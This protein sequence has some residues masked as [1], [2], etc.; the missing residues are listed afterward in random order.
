MNSQKLSRII[1][2]IVLIIVVIAIILL[3]RGNGDTAKLELIGNDEMIIYQYDQFID[4]GYKIVDSSSKNGFY[5]NVDGIVNSNTIGIYFLKYLLYNKNGSLV[6]Y[7]ER[8][9]IVL[10]D[11]LN[12]ISMSLNG[13][14]EE[15]YFV[16]DYVELGATAYQNNNDISHLINI[17][18]N[19]KEDE[20][21]KYEIKYQIV[22]NNKIKEII[23]YVNIID[24]DINENV[25]LANLKINLL[26]NCNNYYYTLQPDGTKEYSK[27]VS[28]SFNDVGIYNFD[29][30]L[31]NGSHKKYSIDISTIDND[32][33]V[34][35]CSLSYENNKTS[36]LMNV[37]DKSGI[38][39]YSYNGMDFYDNKTILNTIASNV[40]VRA[41]DKRNNYTDI[42][43]KAEYGTAFRNIEL[44]SN[45]NIKN[46]TGFIVYPTNFSKENQELEELMQ[47]YGYKTRGA[48]AAAGLYLAESK[49]DVPYFW[50]GKYI[51]K[52][53]NP[54]WGMRHS[55]TVGKPCS[56]PLA[57]DNSYCK[58]GLD[59]TGYTKWAFIQAGFD[60]DLIRTDDQS[61]GRWGGANGTFVGKD[62]RY[63]FSSSNLIYA[64]QIKPGDIVATPGKH[65]GL[66][67]GVSE[68]KIQVANEWAGIKISI[69]NKS[70][71]ASTNSD[72]SFTHFLLM[73]E[74]YKTYGNY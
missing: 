38:S 48:V 36:I 12:N 46:K 74:F 68:D 47:T 1:T 3:L 19:I 57:S 59:C 56:Q 73:D 42:K 20:V 2:I 67:I 63:T 65:V 23:R 43:C 37:T 29:I 5:V 31:K 24:Y 58:W 9:V 11:Q 33:P 55:H 39:K 54:E 45:G 62:H 44:S 52:G 41:Y 6:S 71:G 70:N 60:A 49:Y 7:K 10:K 25:D 66:V 35:T 8:K 15:Y 53:F 14:E 72:K 51:K 18:S 16:N 50:G 28:Y 21:G 22:I 61:G 4:P 32:G 69:I 64:N 34:G 13:E 30:Y 27:D 17:D 26:I 40:T